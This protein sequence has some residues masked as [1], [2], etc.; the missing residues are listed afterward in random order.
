MIFGTL[1]RRFI[2]HTPIDSKFLKFMTRSGTTWRNLTTRISLSTNA[3]GREVQH[4]MFSEASL[5][6]LTKK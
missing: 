2:L 5:D 6:K 1:Q 4:K 3:K